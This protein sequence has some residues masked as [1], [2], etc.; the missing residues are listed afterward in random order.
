MNNEKYLLIRK[1]KA[2]TYWNEDICSYCSSKE[3][4]DS[5]EY[6]L[7][8]LEELEKDILWFLENF[9]N[10]K[11]TIYIIR[12]DY[13]N[14]YIRNIYENCRKIYQEKLDIKKEKEVQAQRLAEA[15]HKQ[16]IIEEELRQLKKLK[17]KYEL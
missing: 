16:N 17:E 11:Y 15:K 6:C 4:F 10:G 8:N 14:N 7:D 1:S 3:F 9:P 12:D 5:R 13:K 2:I